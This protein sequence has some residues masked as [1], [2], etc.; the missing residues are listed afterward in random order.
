MNSG[1]EDLLEQARAGFR[2]EAERTPA[3]PLKEALKLLAEDPHR[4]FDE[5][6]KTAIERARETDK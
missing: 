2:A 3:G 5:L 4:G 6:V 1:R